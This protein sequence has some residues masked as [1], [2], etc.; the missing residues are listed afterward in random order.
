ML[1]RK[2]YRFRLK[3]D[4]ATEEKFN[5]F[6][7]CC[8]FVWNKCLSLNQFRLKNKHW[9]LRYQELN[10]WLQL[11]KQSEEYGFLDKCHSQVLQQKLKDLD[12]AFMDCFDKTLPGKQFPRFR[13]KDLRDS[14]RY[15]QGFKI[16]NRRLYL[17][18]IGW[19]GFFKSQAIEGLPKNITISRQGKHWY[20]SIQVEMSVLQPIP[21]ATKAIGIDVGIATFAALSDGSTIPSINSFRTLE[22]VLAKAQ[23]DLSRKVKFSNNWREQVSQIQLIHTRISSVRR[24]FLHKTSTQISKNHALIVVEDL[25]V[26][27]MSRAAKGTIEEPGIRVKAKSGLNK[28]ILDQGWGEFRRQLEYK[29]SWHGGILISV[30]P[31]YTSQ[32]CSVCHYQDKGNRLSQSEFA[33]QSCGHQSNADI[34]AAKNILAAGLA[35]IACGEDAV[36]TSVKQEPLRNRKKVAA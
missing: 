23:R 7:G 9:I 4:A 35:V 19:V 14:F 1:R 27:N 11:W 3:V 10:F 25:K 22:K 30:N 29:T 32:T 18:K 31:R 28:S 21:S 20:A 2:A 26:K 16:D 17:P 36:A 24:D 13:K 15:P 12:K 34:N 33:C 6:S 5:Q 8:R